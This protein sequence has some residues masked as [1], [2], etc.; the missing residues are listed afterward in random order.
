M[1]IGTE[2]IRHYFKRRALIKASLIFVV[3]KNLL[4][5]DYLR[6]IYIKPR[7]PLL[8]D[9]LRARTD[10]VMSEGPASGERMLCMYLLF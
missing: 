9:Y 5:L 6:F 7:F 2:Y 4:V 1:Y 3:Y 8:A 10:D